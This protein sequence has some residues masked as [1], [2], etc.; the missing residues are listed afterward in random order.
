[1]SSTDLPHVLMYH[2]HNIFK[3]WKSSQ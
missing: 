2:P 1:M 3:G